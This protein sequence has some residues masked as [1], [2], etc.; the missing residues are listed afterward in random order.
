MCYMMDA[1]LLFGS[2]ISVTPLMQIRLIFTTTPAKLPVY[3]CG[4]NLENKIF[5]NHTGC[6]LPTYSHPC[7]FTT[8]VGQLAI[9]YKTINLGLKH[10]KLIEK[11]T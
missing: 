1:C 3:K 8:K 2:Y 9:T 4:N 5:K 11:Y 6:I 10:G 7:L